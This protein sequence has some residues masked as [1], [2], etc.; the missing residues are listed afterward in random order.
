L[1]QALIS[2]AA[3]AYREPREAGVRLL[4]LGVP[5]Q[6]IWPAFGVIVLISV[7]IGGISDLIAPPPVD[8]AVSYFLMA[9]LLGIVFLSFAAGIWKIGQ[10][11][12]GKG[13][14]EESLLIGVF[15]QAAFLPLQALQILLALVLP[16]LAGL[17]GIALLLFGIWVN[18]NFIDAL[19]GFASFGK[20]L[21]VMLLA[22]FV[23]AIA[24]LVAL[25]LFGQSLMGTM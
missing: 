3:Q 7:L 21:G 11:M 16:G 10:K 24:L 8:V 18:V 23:A 17:Y 20:S 25:G 1:E 6:A 15:F 22:S 19:H 9:I 14:F 12:G 4:S 5:T 2:I 13:S